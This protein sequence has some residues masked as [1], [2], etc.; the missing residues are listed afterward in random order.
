MT[1]PVELR[2]LSVWQR[3]SHSF[4]PVDSLTNFSVSGQVRLS[5]A[6]LYQS[7]RLNHASHWHD[8]RFTPCHAMERN[9]ACPWY[10]TIRYD[11]VYLTCSKKLTGG[12]LSPPQIHNDGRTRVTA[13]GC[14]AMRVR[15]I[16]VC[17][18]VP[19]ILKFSKK[20]PRCGTRHDK[21]VKC[22][23]VTLGVTHFVNNS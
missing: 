14:V 19:K 16:S 10:D 23:R 2:S 20:F 15:W 8:K 4:C 3:N 5:S 7:R 12:E 9:S 18:G 1:F 13:W 21:I 11:S 22:T 6:S 17:H